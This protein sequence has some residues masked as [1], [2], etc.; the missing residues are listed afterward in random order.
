MWPNE[1]SQFAV[2]EFRIGSRRLTLA[3]CFD[4]INFDKSK[5]RIVVSG[6]T[7]ALKAHFGESVDKETQ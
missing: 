5:V 1:P 4:H 6:D 7:V 2:S 3:L